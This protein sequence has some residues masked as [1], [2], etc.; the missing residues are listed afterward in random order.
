MKAMSKKKRETKSASTIRKEQWEQQQQIIQLTGKEIYEN[1]SQCL[2][3]TRLQLGSI[4]LDDK[5]ETLAIIGEANLLLGKA[6]QDLRNLA[7]N[8]LIQQ[9]RL[10]IE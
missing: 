9:Q 2:C 3:L 7:K 10:K 8:L 6:V 5:D 4:D 1:V